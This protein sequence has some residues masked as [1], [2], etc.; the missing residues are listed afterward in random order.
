MAQLIKNISV[1]QSAIF[2]ALGEAGK[3]CS[4][5]DLWDR[6]SIKGA[7][8]SLSKLS[9]TLADMHRG[10]TLS[11]VPH[12]DPL[13]PNTKWAYLLAE[14]NKV[15]ERHQV[16]EKPAVQTVSTEKVQV[17]LTEHTVEI[18]SAKFHLILEV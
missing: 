11:R 1:R 8:D 12:S 5:L 16:K 13:S 10:G 18:T 6:A 7:C 4:A 9:I 2:A 14:G 17:R 3:P 15:M